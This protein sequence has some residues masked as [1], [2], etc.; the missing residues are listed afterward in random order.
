MTKLF[1]SYRR[2]DA[3]E[4]NR[5]VRILR[6]E[7][8]ETHIFYDVASIELG[9][10]WPESLERALN[11]ALAIIVIIGPRWLHLQDEETGKRRIDLKQ[12]W[13]RKEIIRTIQ[14]KKENPNLLVIPLLVDG[15][16]MPNQNYLDEELKPLFNYQAMTLNNTGDKKD[17]APIKVKLIASNVFKSSPPPVATPVI[18]AIPDMLTIRELEAFLNKFKHWNIVEYEKPGNPNDTIKE[19]YRMYEFVSYDDAI[20][21]MKKVDEYGIRPYNHHPR[22]QNTYN[23]VE[24]WL[25]TF[26]VGHKPSFRDLRLAE[27]CEDIYQNFIHRPS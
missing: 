27:I 9:D 2:V 5:V 19:L 25:C 17:L 7:F 22:I 10:D 8:G 15:A 16:S 21:F 6:E 20:D 18:N 14:R 24:I 1:I 4:A 12:D 11:E 26:N 23:R 3:F 13:V